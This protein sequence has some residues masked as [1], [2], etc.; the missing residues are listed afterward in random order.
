MRKCGS[1]GLAIAL[2]LAAAVVGPAAVGAADEVVVTTL[3]PARLVSAQ[4][5]EVQEPYRHLWRADRALITNGSVIVI[6]ADPA[7]TQPRQ[8][9]HPYLFVGEWPAEALNVGASGFVVALVPVAPSELGREPIF[10]AQTNILPEAL[11]PS[12]ARSTLSAARAAG[13]EPPSA[14]EL[15]DALAAG[16]ELR[17][18]ANFQ[19]LRRSTAILIA[20]VSPQERDLVSGLQAPRVPTGQST[21]Q[22]IRRNHTALPIAHPAPT[23]AP[24]DGDSGR[25]IS[26]LI[27]TD[28]AGSALGAYPFFEYVSAF[29]AGATVEVAIDTGRF[30]LLV[31]VTADIYV[32]E[33]KT[34][35]EWIADPTLTDVS[36]GVESSSFVAGS[37]TGNTL[38]VDAGSLSDDAGLGLGVGYDIVIDVDDDGSLSAGDVID[39]YGNEAGFYVVHDITLPGPLAVTEATYDGGG[40]FLGQNTFYPTD[41]ASMG[42]L[43]LVIVSHGNGHNY[44]WYDHI[45]NHMASY[46]YV[47]M[48]HQ[49]NTIPGIETSSETTLTNTEYFLGNLGTIEGGVLNGHVDTRRITW[50]GHSRGGEGIA[51]AYDR[52]FDG[53]FV[54]TQFTIDQLALLSSI[55]PTDF[56]GNNN[57][58]PHGVPYHLWVGGSDNDVS[59]CASS[60]IGQSFTL[61][62][63]ALGA[64]QSLS[65]HGVGHG[66]F[67]NGGGSSVATG[68]CLVGRTDTHTIMRGYLLPLIKHYVE[69]NIPAEDFLWRQWESFKPIGAPTSSCVVADLYYRLDDDTTFVI[70]DF[71]SAPATNMSSSGGNVSFNVADF[72]EALLNDGNTNF[73]DVGAADPMNGMTVADGDD[74][75]RGII[76]NYK[77]NRFLEFALSGADRN[78]AGYEYI[79]FRGCQQTR[80]PLTI[81]ELGDTTFTVTLRDGAGTTSSINFGVYGGGLEEPYQRSNCGAGAGWNNEFETVRLRVHDFLHDGSGLDLSNIVAVRFNFGPSF[82]STSGRLGLDQIELTLPAPPLFASGF[83]S[84]DFTDWTNVVQ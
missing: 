71:E 76:F 57:S 33:A 79:S 62:D 78:L 56:L 15:A 28:L 27:T 69:D 16:G 74:A 77:A 4:P 32:V 48:S 50:I 3:R 12:A 70:D 47:V 75:S 49:N 45:G 5:F 58:N 43:P 29:N 67:H 24:T 36:G 42:E 61:L 37:I 7:V 54:P 35:L 65:L 63:R 11:S 81:A 39:G 23:S 84:D 52:V 55:A 40:A 6:E 44:Q 82:G 38:T 2:S 83:E 1:L 59:G 26:G 20:Q 22:N 25:A 10:Y 14:E 66:D 64:R 31:G 21:T 30:P 73:T 17:E 8:N 51:R 13:L 68:P 72:T 80:H 18:L 46:G 53:D 41:I 9:H 34:R 60:G 19:A